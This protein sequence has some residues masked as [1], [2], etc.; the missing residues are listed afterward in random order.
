MNVYPLFGKYKAP[1]AETTSASSLEQ[2]ELRAI[3]RTVAEIEWLL[4][5]LVLLYQVFS[6]TADVAHTAIAMALFLYAAFIMSFH[7]AN[8]YTPVSRWKI[9]IETWGMI[10][11]IT[12]VLWFTG[13][14]ESPLVNTYLL[15]IITSALALGRGITLTELVMIGVCFLIL[16]N[17]SVQELFTLNQIGA[18]VAQFAPLML[19]AYITTMFSSDIR[20][21]LTKAKL[22]A[23]TDELT[24]LLNRRGFAIVAAKMLGQT[25]RHNRELSVL[26][27]DSDNLKQVNDKHGHKAGDQL[28][29][30][31]GKIVQGQLRDT[32][33]LA[34]YGGD[35]FVVLLPDAGATGAFEVAE[36]IRQSVARAALDLS[37][38]PV[39]LTVS[40]GIATYPI[41]GR[42]L[43]A[44]VENADK[45]M[46]R[47]KTQGRDQVFTFSI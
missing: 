33:V 9:A 7:Y 6:K 30:T 46:Y 47:A 11:F 22:V 45:A 42:T 36:R 14:L 28:L 15:V 1:S 34:R 29:M 12:C 43:D 27:I 44:L 10:A 17:S 24:T 21:G 18:M 31:L 32:D 2:E 39:K 3:A 25:V 4:L 26:M 38:T 40:M 20:Y 41:D 16:G 35:E 8:F 13:K 37:G 5:V 19:V 23:E